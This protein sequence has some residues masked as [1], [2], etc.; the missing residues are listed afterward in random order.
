MNKH[1]DNTT[2]MLLD[3][4]RDALETMA[5]IIGKMSDSTAKD[6]ADK[7]VEI[8]EKVNK[9]NSKLFIMTDSYPSSK[10]KPTVVNQMTNN[11][12]CIDR[13]ETIKRRLDGK[14]NA[15]RIIEIIDLNLPLMLE[16]QD[17][18]KELLEKAA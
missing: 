17:K 4:M 3:R 14:D 2:T 8:I 5:E 16:S 1:I 11:L 18:L 6:M 12:K 10:I 9:M 7:T 15:K 13:L